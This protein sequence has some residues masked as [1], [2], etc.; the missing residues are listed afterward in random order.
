M[1]LP[2]QTKSLG[3]LLRRPYQA[4]Q[5]HIY[6]A[7]PKLGIHDIR[8]AHSAVLRNID[9]EGARITVLAERAGMT[10]Q[11]MGYLVDALVS[12]GRLELRPDPSD[13]RAKLAVLTSSGQQAINVLLQVSADAEEVLAQRLGRDNL[14]TLRTLLDQ[15]GQALDDWQPGQ[16]PQPASPD[17]R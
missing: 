16:A 8:V 5:A 9:P 17:P 7:L 11:S 15:A 6:G 1:P 12:S 2:S 4:L 13:G 14:A 3:S 10:K